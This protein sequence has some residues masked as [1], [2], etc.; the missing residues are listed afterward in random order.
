VLTELNHITITHDDQMLNRMRILEG[1]VRGEKAILEGRVS[2]HTQA[3]D[4]LKKWL[5]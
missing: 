4:K 5:K 1:I 3:K 2:S